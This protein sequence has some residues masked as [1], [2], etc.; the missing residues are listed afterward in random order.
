MSSLTA[1]FN[2]EREDVICGIGSVPQDVAYIH[3]VN[4]S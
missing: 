3:V 4:V 1:V 2:R